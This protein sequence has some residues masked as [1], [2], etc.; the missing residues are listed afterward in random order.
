MLIIH[1]L[2]SV[3]SWLELAVCFIIYFPIHFILFIFTAPFDKQ[4]K[5]LHYNTSML[6]VVCLTIIP[7]LRVKTIGR[8]N[9]DR[10]HPHVVV[11]NHQSLLDILFI[12]TIFYP[13][14]MMAKKALAKV[15]IVGW[16][17]A[18]N[19]HILVDRAS[20]KSQ[21]DAIR[22]MDDILLEGD[23]LMIY[24]E[25]TRTKDGQIAEF[26]KGAFRS[27]CNT[28]T[29]I[30]PVVIHGAYEA[31]PSKS[32]LVKGSHKITLSVLPP[33]PVPKGFSTAEL[34]QN[35][36]DAMSIELERLRTT[37]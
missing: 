17:L 2:L 6:C 21:I 19:K 11:M 22:R 24:P 5:I 8:E 35:C 16:T 26:K 30:L 34:A 28:G 12:F 13:A 32:M 9:I 31:L 10:K 25:G 29:A 33:I 1:F 37:T 3:I 15:P 20:R 27:A 14:K 36:H 7:I 23:S 18:L 4:R